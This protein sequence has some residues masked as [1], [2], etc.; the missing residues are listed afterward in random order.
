MNAKHAGWP[1]GEAKPTAR[2]LPEA[3]IDCAEESPVHLGN[4]ISGGAHRDR[5]LQQPRRAR[6]AE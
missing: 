4:R 3:K 1:F 5:R 2:W 6:L